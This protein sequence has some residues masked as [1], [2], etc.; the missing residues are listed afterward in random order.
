MATR[1]AGADVPENK[2]LEIALTYI[3]GIGKSLSNK[4]TQDLKIDK[5]K[6]IKDLTSAEITEIR[7]AITNGGYLL[8][9]DLQREVRENIKRLRDIGTYRGRRHSSS[10]PVRGQR[11][12]T[13]SRTVR[14][15]K[16]VTVGSGRKPASTPT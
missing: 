7:N 3:K 4:I 8:E 14:G 6:K 11:T 9:G 16:R 15:N 1:I 2:R 13:N 5:N 12:K 10:L